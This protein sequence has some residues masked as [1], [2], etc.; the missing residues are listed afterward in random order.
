MVSRGSGEH[1][2]PASSGPVAPA[3]AALKPVEILARLG[4]Y[5]SVPVA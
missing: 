2:V 5:N 3:A 4:A 1:A